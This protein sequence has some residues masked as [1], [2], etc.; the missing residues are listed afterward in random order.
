MK[1]KKGETT[2]KRQALIVDENGT[3]KVVADVKDI[4]KYK[5][6]RILFTGDETA[7]E[8]LDG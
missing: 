4:E 5:N 8:E 3:Y 7:R 1:N 2:M 6:A